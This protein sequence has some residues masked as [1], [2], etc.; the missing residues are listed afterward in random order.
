MNAERM[1]EITEE[2]QVITKD[3]VGVTPGVAPDVWL[4]EMQPKRGHWWPAS[5]GGGAK[6]SKGANFASNPWTKENWN[7]TEQGKILSTQGRE[8][9][10]QMAKAAGTSLG[11][12]KPA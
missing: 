8:K 11:G 9:A 2:G 10:E 5:T 4:S 7:M 3:G 6:G 12:R 1:F